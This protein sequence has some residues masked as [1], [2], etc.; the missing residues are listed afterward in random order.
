MDKVNSADNNLA[1]FLGL[2]FDVFP[3]PFAELSRAVKPGKVRKEDLAT[4]DTRWW[5]PDDNT[6]SLGKETSRAWNEWSKDNPSQNSVNDASQ[7]QLTLTSSVYGLGGVCPTGNNLETILKNYFSECL[8][9][10]F[11][12]DGGVAVHR[13]AN[14]V[15]G[16]QSQHRP[17]RR[18]GNEFAY[19][20]ESFD[21]ESLLGPEEAAMHTIRYKGSEIIKKKVNSLA[22]LLTHCENLGHA[23]AP[24]VEGLNVELLPFQRQSLKWAIE[25]ETMPGGVQSLHWAKV[26]LPANATEE[27][28]FNPLLGMF[29]KTKPNCVRG[30]WICEQMGMG[31]TIISL[32]LVL[33]NVAPALPVSGSRTTAL[34]KAPK[35]VNGQSFWKPNTTSTIESDD[36]KNPNRGRYLSRGTLVVCNVSLVGQWIEEAKSK[37][38]NPEGK[39]YAYYGAS[40]KRDAKILA[41]NAI[42]VTT[43]ETLV[44]D[45][46]YHAKKAESNSYCPPV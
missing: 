35:P 3:C 18:F 14:T 11:A 23:E 17:V 1:L 41:K 45:A 5:N 30:G 6:F 37:L 19:N 12:R 21:P 13:V 46:T 2:W 29:S 38:E 34:A 22:T 9:D 8:P 28:Y 39:I 20:S 15:A 25:R 31:K 26:P 40:R 7:A 16:L 43:Y 4:S 10:E 24:F 42:V 27:L 36:D 44:S 33:S 32:S